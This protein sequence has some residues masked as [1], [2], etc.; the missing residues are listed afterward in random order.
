MKRP[1]VYAGEKEEIV[2]ESGVGRGKLKGLS[3]CAGEKETIATEPFERR[4][5][6]PAAAAGATESDEDEEED[7][8][9]AHTPVAHR[10]AKGTGKHACN[11]VSRVVA[12]ASGWRESVRAH[13]HVSGVCHG[14]GV[15]SCLRRLLR[16]CLRGPP[17]CGCTQRLCVHALDAYLSSL[18]TLHVLCLLRE[19]RRRKRKPLKS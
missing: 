11:K 10:P 17:A 8:L 5:G 14:T 12:S 3:A 4:V 9:H 18:A 7:T 15:R 13:G 16:A 19:A 1:S 6:A 2:G